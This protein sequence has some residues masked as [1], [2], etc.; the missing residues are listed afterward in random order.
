VSQESKFFE[1]VF[2]LDVTHIC[3]TFLPSRPM[4]EDCKKWEC[5]KRGY[6]LQDLKDL[7]GRQ[8]C[9]R[10]IHFALQA[11][12]SYKLPNDTKATFLRE[13]MYVVTTQVEYVSCDVP[14]MCLS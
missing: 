6:P 2:E 3:G 7:F 9:S 10:K 4:Q 12:T 8:C 1:P 14:M 5:K 11:W 13:L